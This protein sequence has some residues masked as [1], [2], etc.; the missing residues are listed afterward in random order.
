MVDLGDDF[1][2]DGYSICATSWTGVPLILVENIYIVS[3]LLGPVTL[4]P[5]TSSPSKFEKW[6]DSLKLYTNGILRRKVGGSSLRKMHSIVHNKKIH[7]R[8]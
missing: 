1:I 7:L 3:S 4:F 5:D 8:F 6:P 2:E